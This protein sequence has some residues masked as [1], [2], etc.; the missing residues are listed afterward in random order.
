VTAPHSPDHAVGTARK[1]ATSSPARLAEQ[2]RG[3]SHRKVWS[4]LLDWK[5]WPSYL[6]AALGLLLFVVLPVH[7]YRLHR[8]AAMLT[9]MIDSIAEGDPDIRLV[10]DLVEAD[11]LGSWQKIEVADAPTATS[12]DFAGLEVLAHSR[13][14]DL[15]TAWSGGLRPDL[16]GQV[17]FRERV[18]LRVNDEARRTRGVVFR[19]VLPVQEVEYRQPKDATPMRVRRVHGRDA[20]GAPDLRYE[21]HV[22]LS[23][24]PIGQPV[25]LELAAIVRFASLPAGRMPMVMQFDADLLTVWMLFPDDHPYKRYQLV[26]YPRGA[27]AAAEPLTSRYTIDHPYGRLIGWSV[28]TPRQGTVYECRWTGD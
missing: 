4:T 11:P 6:Y 16:G 2:L 10:L 17:R 20:T 9:S 5:D 28:I 8:H 13:I 24:A 12:D 3:S 19:T 14:T 22:D 1:A 25:S 18:V 23:R 27:E 7:V 26:T 15:R 21:I